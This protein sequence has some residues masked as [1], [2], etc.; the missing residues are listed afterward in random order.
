MFQHDGFQGNA[1]QGGGELKPRIS[2]FQT[3]AFQLNAFQDGANRVR[4]IR[5]ADGTP[6]FTELEI[7]WADG[8]VYQYYESEAEVISFFV[9]FKPLF[10][11]RRR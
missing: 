2:A 7:K 1:L 8:C 5:W 10:R 4:L 3:D 6:V 11:P 9:I